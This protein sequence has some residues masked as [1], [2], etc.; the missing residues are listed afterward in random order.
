ML[1]AVQER[2]RTALRAF[3]AAISFHRHPSFI[4]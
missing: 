3:H 4:S 1:K 2:W